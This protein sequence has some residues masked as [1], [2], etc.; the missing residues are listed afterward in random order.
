MN[1]FFTCV[2]KTSLAFEAAFIQRAAL[3]KNGK[4]QLIPKV[5]HKNVF[6]QHQIE[7]TFGFAEQEF[8]SKNHIDLEGLARSRGV[9]ARSITVLAKAIESALFTDDDKQKRFGDAMT[10]NYT[11]EIRK[12]ILSGRKAFA[13]I[14]SAD[15]YYPGDVNTILLRQWDKVLH[16]CT[17]GVDIFDFNYDGSAVDPT[18]T[19]PTR[20]IEIFPDKVQNVSSEGD[21]PLNPKFGYVNDI[22]PNV[23]SGI[24]RA[25][26]EAIAVAEFDISNSTTNANQAQSKK[27]SLRDL[28]ESAR[29]EIPL[30]FKYKRPR[31]DPSVQGLPSVSVSAPPSAVVVVMEVADR[32]LVSSNNTAASFFP[33]TTTNG[34]HLTSGQVPPST[35][36]IG[37]T[38]QHP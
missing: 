5:L 28:P 11:D 1:Q 20:Y 31:L 34:V 36:M 35:G 23:K 10:R 16:L 8:K 24:L 6:L 29:N 14:K 7:E 19:A 13:M 25:V 21:S 2:N 12:A 30:H 38:T 27:A 17:I 4:N 37:N 33:A 9:L 22:D 32:S 26:N 15:P 3:E 18:S